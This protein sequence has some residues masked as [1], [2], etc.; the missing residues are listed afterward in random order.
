MGLAIHFSLRLN[1]DMPPARVGQMIEAVRQRCLDLSFERVGD[2]FYLKHG[3]SQEPHPVFIEQQVRAEVLVPGMQLIEV[4]GFT[5]WPGEG[6][7]S[8]TLGMGRYLEPLGGATWWWSGSCKT[9]FAHDRRLGTAH[10]LKCHLAPIASLL[11]ARNLGIEVDVE[12]E[13]G[14]WTGRDE[15][16]LLRRVARLERTLASLV[17]GLKGQFSVSS[18]ILKRD[19]FERLEAEGAGECP[20]QLQA[21]LESIRAELRGE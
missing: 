2:V 20:E 17:G 3:N 12:D 18:D 6:S 13:G 7:E 1:R 19:D 11:A 4:M 21:L 10:F 8:L 14:Y 16:E 5:A 9:Q 15:A